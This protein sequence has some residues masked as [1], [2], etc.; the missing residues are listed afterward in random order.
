MK[1]LLFVLAAAL[2][3]AVI[4]RCV[5]PQPDPPAVVAATPVEPPATTTTTTVELAEPQTVAVNIFPP[6]EATAPPPTPAPRAPRPAP[7]GDVADIIRTGFARFGGDVAEQAVR[8]AMCE[9]TLRPGATNAGSVGVLQIHVPS[10]RA[11]ITR[12]G[13]TPDQLYDP[14]VNAAAAADIWAEQGWQ[15]WTCRWAAA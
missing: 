2:T 1:L 4:V 11:R 12:L 9:S 14:A 10:H 13:Y 7:Q 15:P 3:L 8:V 6:P 5:A